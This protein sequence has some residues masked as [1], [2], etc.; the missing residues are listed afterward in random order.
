LQ[1]SKLGGPDESPVEHRTDGVHLGADAGQAP[2]LNVVSDA[3]R[4][5]GDED[6]Q[7]LQPGGHGGVKP[8]PAPVS[9]V[10]LSARCVLL[11]YFD[12]DVASNIDEHFTRSLQ[13]SAARVHQQQ[14]YRRTANKYRA[15]SSHRKFDRLHSVGYTA[16]SYC[17]HH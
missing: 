9:A 1:S 6:A 14:L 8:T 16:V 17:G 11:T 3:D 12:G 7:S 4:H 13:A 2:A 15:N 5:Q 10:R